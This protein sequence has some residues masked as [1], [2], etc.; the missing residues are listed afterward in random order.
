MEYY[1]K[2]TCASGKIAKCIWNGAGSPWGPRAIQSVMVCLR[3]GWY[4]L[5]ISDWMEWRLQL[6]IKKWKS[7]VL[8]D[9]PQR[10]DNACQRDLLWPSHGPLHN[11]HWLYP[12]PIAPSV[13]YHVGDLSYDLWTTSL[14]FPFLFSSL[15]PNAFFC[16]QT[17]RRLSHHA[18]RTLPYA[19]L[20][21]S[22]VLVLFIVCI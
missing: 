7:T 5:R 4:S 3:A 12:I 20:H 16:G 14:H 8:A 15:L 2:L 1:Y 22:L 6:W 10:R 13:W 18:I 9:N 21:T 17:N 11:H 19:S